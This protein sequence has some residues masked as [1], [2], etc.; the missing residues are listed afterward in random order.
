MFK[1]SPITDKICDI[2]W[3]RSRKL[4]NGCIVN[5][6]H[7]LRLA[8]LLISA[9]PTEEKALELA[10]SMPITRDIPGG[11]YPLSYGQFRLDCEALEWIL[12][13]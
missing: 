11:T 7:L 3:E 10:S 6:S 4:H 5:N 2:L 8:G 12:F 9:S 13:L 1:A